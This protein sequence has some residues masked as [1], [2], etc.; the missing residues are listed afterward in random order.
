MANQCHRSPRRLANVRQKERQFE[1]RDGTNQWKRVKSALRG[2][3]AV[4]P[5][6]QFLVFN[7]MV[8]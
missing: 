3:A 1:F 2:G 7:H 4:V 5:E 6:T 8:V